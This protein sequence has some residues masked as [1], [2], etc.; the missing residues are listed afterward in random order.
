MKKTL[1]IAIIGALAVSVIAA[2][3]QDVLSGNAVGYI[4]VD[5][6]SD[7]SIISV[8]FDEVGYG[9]IMFTNTIGLQMTG[10]PATVYSW[11]SELQ[12]WDGK[13]Y[14]TRD[15]WLAAANVELVPGQAYFVRRPSGWSG[16][17]TLTGQVPDSS[18]TVRSIVGGGNLAALSLA[19][20][21][22]TAFTNTILASITGTPATIYTWLGTTWDGKSYT[23][24]DGWKAA[25]NMVLQPGIGYF[26]RMPS[27]SASTNWTQ[28][29]PYTW[30]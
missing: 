15:R 19:Y 17:L 14:T 11:N 26:F 27:G 3:A 22:E 4:K 16:S 1:W 6:N 28:N 8:P 20:P 10:T 2:S 25:T 23:T 13:A 21:A 24:R 29:K 9:R 5:V 7:L 12:M 18:N 30:P